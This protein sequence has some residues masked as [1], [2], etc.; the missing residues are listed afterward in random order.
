MS[1][2]EDWYKAED[3]WA[4]KTTPDDATRKERILSFA[5]W[6]S[7]FNRALDIGCGEGWITKDLPAEE[8]HG[9]EESDN[10]AERFP[11]NV[12]RVLE[13]EGEY[14]LILA[15]GVLYKHYEWRKMLDMIKKYRAP[16]SVVIV[17]GIDDWLV[18]E[19]DE[20]GES[21]IEE[22][23]PYRNMVQKIYVFVT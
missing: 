10:A 18:D 13:P 20:L 14:D 19:I 1:E 12:K 17:A 16:Q 23:F 8:I 6:L 2:I 22:E 4:Y 9:Y 3:P 21:E 15:A 5:E 11:D 7:P